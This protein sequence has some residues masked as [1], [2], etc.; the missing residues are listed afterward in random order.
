[1]KRAMA[2]K[3]LL[4]ALDLVRRM[5]PSRIESSLEELVDLVP[6]LTDDLLNTI[7]QPLQAA[8]DAKGNAY[9]NCDYNRDGDSYRSP[10][11][12][13]YDPP[14]EDGVLPPQKLRNLE[15]AANDLFNSYREM[16][17]EGGVS[18]V[19]FWEIDG[20]F[21]ACILFKK[22]GDGKKGLR[23]GFWDAIHVVEV[24]PQGGSK[25]KYKL[26]STI[27]LS[28]ETDHAIKS[29]TQDPGAGFKLSGSMTRQT[30]DTLVGTQD[31]EHLK[32]IGRMLEEMENRMRDSL[33][34]V[35]FGK[36][37]TTVNQLYRTAGQAAMEDQK[38]ALASE[39]QASL[40]KK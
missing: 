36:T 12:N 5:P 3:R 15:I 24:H 40:G 16:Y 31:D 30:E 37:K 29:S 8:K 21:A 6:D 14:I 17:Y 9:L 22:S 7:D 33:Q 4:A 38:K 34:T 1:V 10:W 39:L 26:T 23:A 2:D 11:T 28:L 27:M 35:Y 25:S 20:G 32:N 19:Y 13:E 18:S